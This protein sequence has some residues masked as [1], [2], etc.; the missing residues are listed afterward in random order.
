MNGQETINKIKSEVHMALKNTT[1]PGKIR[2]IALVLLDLQM[3]L[4]N[5]IKVIEEV[6]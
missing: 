5:G 3:P 2:P 1:L 6:R 4:K